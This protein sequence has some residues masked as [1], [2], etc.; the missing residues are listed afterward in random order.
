MG[1]VNL[2]VVSGQRIIQAQDLHL[3]AQAATVKA[4]K[5]ARYVLAEGDK[6]GAPENITLKRQGKNLLVMPE[7][8]QGEPQLVIENFYDYPGELVGM[9][10][11]GEW[12]NYVSANADS[13]QET[14]ALQD[15]DVSPVLLSSETTAAFEHL[16]MDSNALTLGLIALGALSTATALV[17]LTKSHGG[18]EHKEDSPQSALEAEPHTAAHAV[19]TTMQDNM[20]SEQGA[21]M[22]G[23]V[24]DDNTPT[25]EGGGQ[26]PGSSV[27][28]RDNG[29]VIGS[30]IADKDGNWS[31]TPET[32]LPDGKHDLVVVI[33]DP[34][35]NVSLPSDPT[36]I[37]IDTSSI[38]D[39][40]EPLPD[41]AP[42]IA[43]LSMEDLLPAQSDMGDWAQFT[44]P[45][46]M[47]LAMPMSAP[48]EDP[49]TDL[50]NHSG[51]PF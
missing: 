50:L 13:A 30:A 48:G 40:S 33:T 6:L 2:A 4:V 51:L 8:S 34:Q 14:A 32:A 19:I 11:S 44:L 49:I 1:N 15:G 22:P 24:T 16:S 20:G 10:E 23:A 37:V 12:H 18:D 41:T 26:L 39:S 5:G 36:P 17:F 47:P 25:L 21:V 3:N 27:E 43:P 46:E 35:G 29:K 31:F 28:I 7:G 9:S 45:E 42:E 38:A